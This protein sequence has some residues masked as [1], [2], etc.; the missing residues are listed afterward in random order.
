MKS[1]SKLWYWF[2]IRFPKIE[3][4]SLDMVVSSETIESKTMENPGIIH[5]FEK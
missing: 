2:Y 5:I 4:I 1:T 3:I